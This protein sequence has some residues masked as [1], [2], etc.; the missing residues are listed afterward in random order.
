MTASE[1]ACQILFPPFTTLAPWFL[2]PGFVKK[3]GHRVEEEVWRIREY[4]ARM[5]ETF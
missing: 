2:T 5:P 4:W 1:V 3:E